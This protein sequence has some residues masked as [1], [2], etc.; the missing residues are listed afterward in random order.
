M[1]R[2]GIIDSEQP[3]E[4]ISSDVAEKE[5][6]RAETFCR[7]ICTINTPQKLFK[8]C[9]L[10]QGLKN[11]SSIFQNCIES[12]LKGIKGALIFQDDVLVYKTTNEQFYKRMLALKSP[13]LEKNFTIN[14][15]KI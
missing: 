13:L 3:G 5:E 15:K 11:P 4:C 8:M 9:Q 12:T 2:Q 1:V 7:I 10:T 14:K 6:W